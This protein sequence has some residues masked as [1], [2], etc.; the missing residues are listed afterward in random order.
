MQTKTGLT[1]LTFE[2]VS[3]VLFLKTVQGEPLDEKRTLYT[4]C[5]GS[6]GLVVETPGVWGCL[7]YFFM[8]LKVEPPV[9]FQFQKNITYLKLLSFYRQK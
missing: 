4:H 9:C 5:C 3:L 7:V 6:G 8:A 2:R 1:R